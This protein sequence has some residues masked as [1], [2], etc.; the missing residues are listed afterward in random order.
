MKKVFVVT[1]DGYTANGVRAMDYGS[2]IYLVGVFNDYDDA[3]T[4]ALNC[5]G[6]NTVIT[7][8]EPNQAFPL[9]YEDEENHHLGKRNQYFLGGYCE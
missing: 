4:A 9:K 1:A 3:K 6:A 5:G 2:Q 7:I 8:V